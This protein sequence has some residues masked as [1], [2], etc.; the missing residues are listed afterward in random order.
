M[1]A[2]DP[3]LSWRLLE[4]LARRVRRL[5]DRVD[6]LAT[7]DVAARLAAHL[8]ARTI[9]SDGV[10]V[11]TLEGTQADL[12]EELGTVREVV[13]RALR[14]L[15]RD[16]LVRRIGPGRYELRH[17]DALRAMADVAG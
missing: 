16:G 14:A 4:T 13:V 2:D 3:R 1:M 6:A 5:V 9:T 10:P 17:V 11:A 7:Q 8:L 15:H 12:A